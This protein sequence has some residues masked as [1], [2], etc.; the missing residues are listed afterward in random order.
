MKLGRA[1]VLA[2]A[3]IS[4]T[5]E[6]EPEFSGTTTGGGGSTGTGV[7]SQ[8]RPLVG[9]TVVV[10]AD[11]TLAAVSDPERDLVSF[12]GLTRLLLQGTVQL[13]VGSQPSRATWNAQGLLQVVLRGT[14]EVATIDPATATVVSTQIVC[15][16]PRGI[17]WDATQEA[18]LVACATGE[19]V[20]MRGHELEVRRLDADLRDVTVKDGHVKV[21]AFRAPRVFELDAAPVVLPAVLADR[22]MSPTAAYRML[23]RGDVTIV[24]HQD[25]A[26]DNVQSTPPT[27]PTTPTTRTVPAYYGNGPTAS[28]CNRAVVRSAVTLLSGSRVV[29]RA[30]LPGVLPIDAALSR[31]GLEL[32]VIH[33]G[34]SEL[35]RL[36]LSTLQGRTPSACAPV[37][38]PPPVNAQGAPIPPALG[39]PIGVAYTP[40]G[41][42]LVHSRDPSALFVISRRTNAPV[43]VPLKGWG[44]ETAGQK[45]F[46]QGLG[47]ISCASCHPEGLEDGH[48]WT[49][50]GKRRRTQS[51]AGG[52]LKTAPFHWDGSLRNLEAVLDETFVRR[53]GGTKPDAAVVRSLEAMLAALPA[54]KPPS[55][56]SVIDAARG[57]AAFEKAAC[58]ACHRGAQ[59]TNGLTMDVGSGGPLQVPSLVGLGRR[60]PWMHDGCAKTLEER[61]S[62]VTCGGR[63]HGS[64]SS[65]TPEEQQDLVAWLGQL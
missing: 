19:L 46:H 48:V 27:T 17:A 24:V 30:Q 36:P 55:S 64:V 52:L 56:A 39:S 22:P 25:A 41:D 20:T 8:T 33:A 2:L 60:G 49:L 28:A 31:D 42:L 15:A 26:D 51:L 65:L 7:T 5:P 29:G 18:T 12:V 16:E 13:P 63:S 11:G 21:S 14:G 32:A 1:A 57:R 53:M 40:S 38:A 23:E 6:E 62:N 43:R 4:C 45:L 34:N 58:T 61:F 54:P 3:V 47:G 59:L 44:I 37:S 10:N 35:V 9:G 50:E